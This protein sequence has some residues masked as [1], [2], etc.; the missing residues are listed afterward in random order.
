M[1]VE[2]DQHRVRPNADTI[3]CPFV[4]AAYNNGLLV[5]TPE[6]TVHQDAIA[7]ALRAVG[8]AE[9]LRTKLTHVVVKADASPDTLN[10]FK[11]RGSR[12]DHTG[13][14]GIRDP[15]VTPEKL[16]DLLRFGENGRMYREH[17][18]RAANHFRAESP[19]LKGAL[20]EKIEFTAVL[21]VFGRVD[22][23]CER[24]GE[25]YLTD[26]DIEGLWLHG[27]YPEDWSPR[28]RDSITGPGFLVSA[29]R[30]VFDGI[31]ATVSTMISDDGDSAA[32]AAGS[33]PAEGLAP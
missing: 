23:C 4:T 7:E 1:K 27:R 8:L 24:K 22:D 28:P 3:P 2:T 16:P 11:L 31:V 10:I 33:V 29:A 18:A 5:P 30:T 32:E 19:G 13:S 6:G 14:T 9:G 26:A 25:R 15:E 20:A 21:E 17:F 12:I